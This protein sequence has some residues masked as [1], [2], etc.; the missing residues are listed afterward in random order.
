MNRAGKYLFVLL[1][2]W[3]PNFFANI[4]QESEGGFGVQNDEGGDDNRMDTDVSYY[5][6]ASTFNL[7]LYIR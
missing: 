2:V 3:I 7:L 4:V 5:V 1:L 6:D